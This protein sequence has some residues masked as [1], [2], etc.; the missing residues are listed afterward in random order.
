VKNQRARE[1]CCAT[2]RGCNRREGSGG[3]IEGVRVGE[4]KRRVKKKKKKKRKR[5]KREKSVWK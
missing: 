4:R 1:R 2:C 5:R 3:G